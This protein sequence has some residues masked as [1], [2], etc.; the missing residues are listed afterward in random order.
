[1]MSFGTG[2][3]ASSHDFAKVPKA[4][5]PRSQFNRS[6]TLK[7]AFD[8]DY[9]VPIFIDEVLPGD[10][11]KLKMSTFGRLSTPIVPFMDNVYMDFFFF[12]VPNRLVWSNWEK[13]NGAQTNPGDSISYTIPTMT[14]PAS[15]YTVGSL[16]DYFG[17]PTVG[18][19]TA[20]ND[21]VNNALP[22]RAYNL[23]YN[24]WFR[25]QNIINSV[26]VDIDDGPDTYS[27]YV[28][29]KRGKRH[30]Y[31]TSALPWPQK[32]TAVSIPLGTSAPVYGPV[33]TSSTGGIGMH[34]WNITDGAVQYG[35]FGKTAGALTTGLAGAAGWSGLAAGDSMPKM[36]LATAAEYTSLGSA[37]SPPVADLSAATAATINQLRQAFQQQ[38]LIERDARGGTRYTEILL[39]HFGVSAPDFR[40]QRP[41]YLGGG[42]SRVN[43]NPVAQTS[44]TAGS[45]PLGLMAGYGTQSSSGIG[46]AKSFVEHGYIIGL[47]NVRADLTYQQGQNKLWNR[48]TRYDFYWPALAHIG[49]QTIITGEIYATGVAASDDVV[50]GYQERYAEYRYQP[51]M[52]TGKLKSTASGTLDVWHAAQKFT[53]APTLNSTFINETLPMSRL[54]AVNTEPFIIFDAYFDLVCARPMPMYSVPGQIDR[55]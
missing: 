36:N 5:I 3:S 20:A 22:F 15:G 1:M 32:G 25:D 6:S 23:I 39:S 47:A 10:T 50:F 24:N 19:V 52:I 12:Y 11:F 9:L 38:K 48:S 34:G 55:F 2:R 33:P 31:F 35:D 30:D 26:T 54:L 49:E 14:S 7:T 46:F 43:V 40:L 8:A 42:S 53:A 41:E 29:L 27:D 4:D 44:A 37:F 51:S 17:L 28:N 18:Q 13:F 21:T 45:L 16:Q